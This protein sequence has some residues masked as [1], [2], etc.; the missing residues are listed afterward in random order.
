MTLSTVDFIAGLDAL[1]TD[2]A[3]SE[4]PATIA[5]AI[6]QAREL[7][8]QIREFSAGL[9][10]RYCEIA[11]KV[12]DVAGVGRVEIKHDTRRSGWESEEIL[13]RIVA[14]AR[15]ERRYDLDT[16]E[17]LE[18]EFSCLARVLGEV[19]RFEWRSTALRGHGIEPDDFCTVQYGRPTMK[20]A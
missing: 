18:D 20:V 17:Q 5:Q 8:R 12:L 7:I 11:P 14:L 16:G 19:A 15:D 1:G 3:E 9:E 10:Q 13:K 4:D 6:A 2:L